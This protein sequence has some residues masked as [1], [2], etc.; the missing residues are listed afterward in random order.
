MSELSGVRL[1]LIAAVA[2]LIAAGGVVL[3]LSGVEERYREAAEPEPEQMVRVIVPRQNMARGERL[4][5]SK[6]AARSIPLKFAPA[7]GLLASDI[8]RVVDR[9][10]LTDVQ[11]G[12][13]MTWHAVTSTKARNFSDVVELGKRALSV[14]V[15]EVDSVDGLLRPGDRIDLM[16]NFEISDLGYSQ[17]QGGN[18]SMP[19]E[20]VMAVVQNVEVIESARVDKNGR[21]YENK[22]DKNSRDGIDL[23]FTLITLNLTPRQ[24]ARVQLAETV[25]DVFAVLR[26]SADSSLVD[27]DYL[28]V[29]ILLTEDEPPAQ[30]LVIGADGKPVG[31]IVGDKIVDS[32]GNVVGEV[33]D[34]QAVGLDGKALGSISRNV[35]ADDP[36]NRVAEVSDVIR[37]AQGNIVGRVVDG[38]V[39]DRAGNVIGEVKNGRAVSTSGE[40]LGSVAKGVALDKNGNEVNLGASSVKQDVV[41]GSDGRPVGRIV[42]DNVVD[43]NGNVVGKVV[44]GQAVALDGSSLGQVVRNVSA[45]DPIAQV[46]EVADV[47][48]DKNGNIVG[49][50]VDGRVVDASGNVVGESQQV[51]RDA[52]GRVIGRIED[53]QI[54]DASGNV[55]GRVDASG[56]AVANDG[57]SLGRIDYAVIGNDGQELGRVERNVALDASGQ[58]VDL[59]GSALSAKATRTERVIRDASGNIVGKVVDGQV[60]DNSGK[61]IGTV[62]ANGEARSLSGRSLGKAEQ[63][64]VNDAGVVVGEQ[65]EVVRDASGKVIGRVVNG[66]IVDA[67]GK[68]VGKVDASGRAV[69]AD[70][71]V[72]GSVEKAMVDRNG[73]VVASTQ[74][75]VRN[76]NGEVVG[77]MVGDQLVDAS[78]KVLGKREQV[79]RD[80]SGKIIGRVQDG[81]ILDAS[82]KVIGKVDASGKAVANDGSALG[83]LDQAVVGK[84]LGELGQ[85]DEVM[86]TENGEPLEEGVS[87]VRDASGQ[88]IG[89]LVNGKVVNA[90]GEVVGTYEN[91][92]VVSNTGEVLAEGVTI[93][94]ADA[95]STQETLE[96]K[97]VEPAVNINRV[98][99]FIPG[100]TAKDGIT[101]VVK[102][103]LQ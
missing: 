60:V 72:L 3:Y 91:G 86:V 81:K 37:D 66:E 29:D 21:R 49:K 39:V 61:V 32:D 55:V 87:V 9:T 17:A 103:R 6:L 13:P 56:R 5:R 53:G 22:T 68:V 80:A 85:E 83:T 54:I 92:V 100:G 93:D 51:V 16:G 27:F 35:S 20:A 45:S 33:V 31:R 26:N 58:E 69:S 10:L 24:V 101:P 96:S 99:D 8:E 57:S 89:K 18:Q 25:G 30:D 67:D 76:A 4:D 59:S 34:G 77:R 94:T 14:R 48:R 11:F 44:N 64:L 7:N 102:V 73:N 97:A 40:V 98:V 74:K 42:G 36:I 95:A 1:L 50:I 63:V 79:V 90:L 38:K 88:V 15:N 71:Q 41:I 70:G 19:E 84:D 23:E 47:V 43:Q 46:A 82:G 62:D 28:G 12:R 52:S 2:G 75:V 78:G 65:A